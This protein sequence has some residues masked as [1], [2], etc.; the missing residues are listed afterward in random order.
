MDLISPWEEC[1]CAGK[2]CRTRGPVVATWDVQFAP[3]TE[4]QPTPALLDPGQ[5]PCLP[6]DMPSLLSFKS[7]MVSFGDSTYGFPTILED[8]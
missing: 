2:A 8:S 4:N 6:A 5:I 3:T 7:N 1:L